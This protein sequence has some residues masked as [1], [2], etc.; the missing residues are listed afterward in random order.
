M[1]SASVF[2]VWSVESLPE[3]G[4]LNS[5]ILVFYFF[6][7]KLPASLNNPTILAL[8]DTGCESDCITCFLH[9]VQ[10]DRKCVHEQNE[11]L[12]SVLPLQTLRLQ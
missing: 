4:Y 1:N 8:L 2:S 9:V 11:E 10:T 7:N 6:C 3:L 12:V 5:F